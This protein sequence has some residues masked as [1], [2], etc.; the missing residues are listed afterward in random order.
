MGSLAVNISPNNLLFTC[1]EIHL[2]TTQ[3][4]RMLP[5]RLIPEWYNYSMK[6]KSGQYMYAEGM[7]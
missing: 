1:T 4:S 7:K 3:N 2:C 5:A 6:L